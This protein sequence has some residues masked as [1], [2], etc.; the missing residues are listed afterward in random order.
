MRTEKII[1]GLVPKRRNFKGV[2]I[3]AKLY[4]SGIFFPNEKFVLLEYI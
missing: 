4:L 1:D 2:W 3:P